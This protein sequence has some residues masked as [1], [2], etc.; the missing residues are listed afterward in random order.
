MEVLYGE[1]T[2]GIINTNI[3]QDRKTK[4]VDTVRVLLNI[5]Q[6]AAV[7]WTHGK[8][9]LISVRCQKECVES[10]LGSYSDI[11]ARLQVVQNFDIKSL[12]HCY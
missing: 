4:H 3:W 9:R 1:F 7:S 10:K 6:L 11:N 5:N 2:G 8:S 12:K